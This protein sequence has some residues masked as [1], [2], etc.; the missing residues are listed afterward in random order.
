MPYSFDA[1]GVYA[2]I[3]T[4]SRRCYIGQSRRTKKRLSDHFN[5]LRSG[6]HPNPYLQNAYKKYGP[7]SFHSEIVALCTD[8]ED[9][10]AIEGAFLSG[11]CSYGGMDMYNIAKKPTA[12]M[13][14]RTHSAETKKKIS[15]SKAGQ[16]NH[17]TED[18]RNRL[19]EAQNARNARRPEF[20][21]RV[22]EIIRLIEGGHSYTAVGR[23]LGRDAGSIRKLYLR[24]RK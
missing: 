17:V 8:P 16:V 18:Y 13:A 24:H 23:M 4:T 2:I 9:L 10:D 7:E 11:E 5:L 1:C 19:S 22:A 6:R 12:A 15:S 3:N 21:A 20:V 14:G